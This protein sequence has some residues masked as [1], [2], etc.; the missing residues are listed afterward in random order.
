[1]WSQLQDRW[2][3]TELERLAR[4]RLT[5]LANHSLAI[6]DT[7]QSTMCFMT[8]LEERERTA[9][10]SVEKAQR[11]VLRH[12]ATK[13]WRFK[14]R[15]H[16]TPQRTTRDIDDAGFLV[17]EAVSCLL[18]PPII[19]TTFLN[20]SSA[21]CS[22]APPDRQTTSPARASTFTAEV[23]PPPK[24]TLKRHPFASSSLFR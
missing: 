14:R 1:M 24:K 21:P 5:L 16:S 11:N 22:P 2:K 7:R 15:S 17:E 3:L 12:H 4:Y 9:V 8:E 13:G 19:D 20:P 10:E 6:I 18:P 23:P